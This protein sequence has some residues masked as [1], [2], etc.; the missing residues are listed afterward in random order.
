MKF[1]RVDAS[2]KIPFIILEEMRTSLLNIVSRIQLIVIHIGE[3]RDPGTFKRGF[4]LLL[5]VWKM[6]EPISIFFLFCHH[7]FVVYDHGVKLF[8]VHGVGFM[9][10]NLVLYDL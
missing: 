5:S 1:V 2:L 10:F 9:N 6:F 7:V 4:Y 3:F 8:A